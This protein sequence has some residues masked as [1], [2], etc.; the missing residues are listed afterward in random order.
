[1]FDLLTLFVIAAFVSAVAG[2]MLLLSWLQNR[3]VQALALW[4]SAFIIGSVGVAL[5]A[6]RGDIPDTWSIGIANAIMATAYGIMWAGVRNFD[7][8]PTSAP[9]VFAGAAI[10]LLACHIEAFFASPQARTA[11]MSAIIVLYS[12]LS[13]WEFWR[14]R[15]EG[16]IFRLP[17]ICLLLVHAALFMIRIPLAGALPL[18][19]DSENIHASWWI[20]ITFEAVFFSFCIPYLLG[21]MAKERTV[22][23]YK[24]AS[25]IDPLTGVGNRRAFFERG[26]KLLHRSA[27]DRRPTVLLLF[28]LDGFKH[29]NDTF[30]HHV[31]DQILTAFCGVATAALRPDDLFGRLGG[32]E[33]SCLLPH[34][35]LDKGLAVAERIRSNFEATTL[36][37]GANTLAATV[38]VGIAM[39]IDQ[40]RD[41]AGMIR[42][43][44]RA[45]YRAKAKGRNRVEY[46]SDIPEAL[47]GDV[48]VEVSRGAR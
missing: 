13:A 46:A 2:F 21:G 18:P 48:K 17:V 29:I 8:R 43:A 36:E 15:K 33:F 35:S 44:D 4:A 10:W 31:G 3:N 27:F 7:G 9:L 16:L 34:A 40:K 28:D 14:G 47:I 20:F 5:I 42:A 37:V 19:T 12:V 32:E 24:H 26:E 11:L 22:L 25:L 1:M 30:G 45:L 6:A 41:L 39:S 23:G 38:S